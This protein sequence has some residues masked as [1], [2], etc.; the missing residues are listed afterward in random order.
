MDATHRLKCPHKNV[1][2]FSE[3]RRGEVFRAGCSHTGFYKYMNNI[4]YHSC[5]LEESPSSNQWKRRSRTAPSV[6]QAVHCHSTH[7]LFDSALEVEAS[8]MDSVYS[9]FKGSLYAKENSFWVLWSLTLPKLPLL[10]LHHHTPHSKPL[11]QNTFVL[12]KSISSWNT[13]QS[14][15]HTYWGSRCS[16][17]SDHQVYQ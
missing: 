5:R 14:F 10:L 3:V 11:L 9:I 15:H 17:F 6:V 2:R 16:C 13:A 4:M 12:K 7:R 1:L 8:S